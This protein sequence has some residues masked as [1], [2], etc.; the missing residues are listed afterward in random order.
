MAISISKTLPN[1]V[2]LEYFRIVSVNILV[3]NQCIIEVAGYVS[4]EAREAEQ[5]AL[6]EA[7][8]TGQYPQT[9]IFVH[10]QYLAVD[11]DPDMSVNKA[12]ALIK[13]MEDF[14]E[15]QDVI[16]SWAVG[17]SYYIGDMVVYQEQQYVCLQSHTAQEGYEPDSN[18]ALW[19]AYSEGGD[20]IPVWSQPDSTN[21]Y[22]MGDKVHYP[23]ADGPVYVSTQDYNVFAPNVAGWVLEGGE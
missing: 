5:A 13:G 11:Y 4:Q 23:D 18:P 10:T 14:E 22:M 15:A 8:E 16:D 1:G 17:S 6:A 19:N 20:G 7:V 9:D 12:Y 3:N 2:P 21:P